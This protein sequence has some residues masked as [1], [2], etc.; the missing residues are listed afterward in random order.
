[1]GRLVLLIYHPSISPGLQNRDTKLRRGKKVKEILSVNSGNN[2]IEDYEIMNVR[3]LKKWPCLLVSR[4]KI[5]AC[6]VATTTATS[7]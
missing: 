6:D 1:M 4:Y 5:F 7:Y 2:K 3:S